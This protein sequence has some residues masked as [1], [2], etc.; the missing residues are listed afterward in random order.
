[1]N[2]AAAPVVTGTVVMLIGLII[3]P[4]AIN[5]FRNYGLKFSCPA[6]IGFMMRILLSQLKL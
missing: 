2:F 4:V 5:C 1:M 6:I 3:I